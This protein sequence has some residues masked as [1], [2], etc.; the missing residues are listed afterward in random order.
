MT[1][2]IKNKSSSSFRWNFSIGNKP[3]DGSNKLNISRQENTF[4]EFLSNNSQ[5][6]NLNT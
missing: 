6:I 3:I 2:K 1:Q 5:K 4:L